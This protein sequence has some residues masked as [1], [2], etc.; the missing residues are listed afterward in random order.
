MLKI[1]NEKYR[2][3]ANNVFA[4]SSVPLYTGYLSNLSKNFQIAFP[5]EIHYKYTKKK[6]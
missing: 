2:P 4:F 5:Y 6:I 1:I 3:Y